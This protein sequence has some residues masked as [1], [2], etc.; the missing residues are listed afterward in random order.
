MDLLIAGTFDEDKRVEN[1][2]EPGEKIV[3][4]N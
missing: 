1:I 3:K 2:Y 4:G